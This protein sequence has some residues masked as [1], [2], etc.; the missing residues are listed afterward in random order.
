MSRG[1]ATAV[2]DDIAA[3]RQ[4]R[5]VTF[6]KLQFDSGT[7]YLHDSVG[8]YSW[9][10]PVDGTQDWLGVGD[11]GGIGAVEENAE[12]S[13]YEITL[14]LSGL[15]ADLMDEVLE[16]PYQGRGVTIFLGALDL[17]TGLLL[18]TPNEIWSGTMDV[19]RMTLGSGQNA[20]EITCESDFAKL[21]KINGRTFS[22]SDLQAE[23]SGDTFLQYLT[24]MKDAKIV[25]RGESRTNFSA[26]PPPSYPGINWRFPWQ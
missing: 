17:D 20:V 26:P 25:W 4:V 9:A 16:Q 1:I 24:S 12:M 13:S 5:L 11:F 10:D 2:T 23:F 22:D 8:T 19:G 6:A 3:E 21:D 14:V 15:D 7:V 18:A